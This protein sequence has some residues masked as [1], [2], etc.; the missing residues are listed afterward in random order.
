ME[1]LNEVRIFYDAMLK[2]LRSEKHAARIESL[3][4]KKEEAL[5]KAQTEIRG[6]QREKLTSIKQ[7]TEAK[8]K[9]L[10]KVKEEKMEMLQ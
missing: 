4:A 9:Q 5:E 10:Q 7:A 3:K 8:K 2:N 1:R 6:E